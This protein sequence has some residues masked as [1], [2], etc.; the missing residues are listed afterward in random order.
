MWYKSD[1]IDF[2]FLFPAFFTFGIMGTTYIF[3]FLFKIILCREY[4]KIQRNSL[5][6]MCIFVQVTH[7]NLKKKKK[8]MGRLL[9]P[10]YLILH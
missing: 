5:S 4:P 10:R 1:I 3:A 7:I 9:T 2:F 8:V 6:E